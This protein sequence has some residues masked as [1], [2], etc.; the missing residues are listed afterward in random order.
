[1]V[2]GVPRR[3]AG[4]HRG[5]HAGVLFR[6]RSRA[7]AARGGCGAI[8]YPVAVDNDYAIWSGFANKY[9]PALYFVD[10]EGV[11]RDE[12]FGEGR[13]QHSERIIQ[14][15]LGLERELV[16]VDGI[17]VE[18]AADWDHL[19]TPETYLGDARGERSFTPRLTRDP[20]TS[21][22]ASA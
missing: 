10:A 1:M 8:D 19:R 9:W 5:P 21:P 4:R 12:H 17:G 14:R 2:A 15:L 20:A 7:G 16:S 6:A 3:R 22:G 18:A 11:I 13:Y